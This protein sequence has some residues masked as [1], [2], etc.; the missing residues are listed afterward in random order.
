MSKRIS[1][2]FILKN[3]VKEEDKEVYEY[4]FEI[5]LSSILNFTAVIV[6]AI[7]TRKIMEAILFVMGFVPLRT[8]AGGYHAKN[9]F[10][11]FLILLFT[12]SLFLLTVFF[13]P[14]KFIVTTTILLI[15]SSILLI[16]LLSPVEDHNKPLTEEESKKFKRK[17]RIS[18]LVYS[19]IVFGLSFL[20]TNKI[21]GFSLAF[22]IFSVSFS[23][24]ASV[25]RNKLANSGINA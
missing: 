13:I 6:L 3:I 17:S 8:L 20:F 24:L 1:S 15:L 21:F 2:F 5:L 10:R 12:Y 4:S 7:F 19:L 25:I 14:V 18:I 16:F 22:G 11:C 23:L 9:H